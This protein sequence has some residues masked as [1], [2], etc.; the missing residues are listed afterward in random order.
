MNVQGIGEKSFLKLPNLKDLKALFESPQY[1][2]WQSFRDTEDARYVGLCM[3][4]F[5]LR[6]PYGENQI[7]VKAFNFTEDVVDSHDKYLWGPASLAM[8]RFGWLSLLSESSVW[9]KI[10]YRRKYSSWL[11]G[12]YL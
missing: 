6:L 3:P 7:P 4:R 8:T 9:L 12:S 5:L 1:A 10:A 2:R 11:I